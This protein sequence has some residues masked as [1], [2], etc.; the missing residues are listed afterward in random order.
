METQHLYTRSE[1]GGYLVEV[2]GSESGVRSYRV[3]KSP[4]AAPEEYESTRAL[5]TALMGNDRHWTHDRYFRLGEWSSSE[6]EGRREF[7]G[8]I[9]DLFGE[10]S[11]TSKNSQ[12]Q[13]SLGIDLEKRG[14]EI[15][16]LLF[17][18]FGDMIR[19]YNYDED[20]VLQEVYAGILARNAGKSAWDP[21][22]ASFGYY[23]HMVC[24]SVLYNWHR[25]RS[26]YRER[27]HVGILE[28]VDGN[29]VQIDVGSSRRLSTDDGWYIN[30]P[31]PSAI[32]GEA[33]P[34]ESFK[35]WIERTGGDAEGGPDRV[36]LLQEMAEYVYLGY[37]QLEMSRE[38]GIKRSQY[39]DLRA[40][41]E[42][43][44]DSWESAGCP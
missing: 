38:M 26:R 23:V 18:G 39:H 15:P 32:Q 10:G 33:G 4:G 44:A 20:E 1:H 35:L 12:G 5:L 6:L 40:D 31:D 34:L 7:Q 37:K 19:Q 41:L 3:Q 28:V 14:H 16:K 11:S 27:Y 17:A 9:F 2:E 21:D 30:S 8:L 42:A 36:R 13:K 29:A 25:R 22:K 43:L 24:R